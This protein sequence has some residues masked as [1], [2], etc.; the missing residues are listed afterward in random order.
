VIVPTRELALQTKEMFEKFAREH[1]RK[2]SCFI[3]GTNMF[4]EQ[5]SVQKDKPDVL[6]AT[7]G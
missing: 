4:S 6:I 5:Q 1:K 2:L 7:P 3:G